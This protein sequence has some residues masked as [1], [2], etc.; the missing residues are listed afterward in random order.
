MAE[1]VTYPLEGLEPDNLLAF[2]SLL[3][4]LRTLE[5][6]RPAWHPRI[7]WTVDAAPVR[8][9]L[10]VAGRASEDEICAV[11]AQGLGKFARRHDFGELK[12]LKLSPEESRERLR[13]AAADDRYV[14]DLWAALISDAVVRDRNKANVAEPTPLCL[15]FGQGHMHF[16]SRLASVPQ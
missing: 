15:L 14:A 1:H 16:M 2:L 4:L 8:P 6:V 10:S 5:Q 3:G 7:A 12:D 9:V 11:V 13:A